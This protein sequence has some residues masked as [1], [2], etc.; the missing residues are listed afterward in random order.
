MDQFKEFAT[1]KTH[2]H[3]G[4]VF[5]RYTILNNIKYR[6]YNRSQYVK[7]GCECGAEKL[8]YYN[9]LNL[10]KSKS[11][12]CLAKEITSKISRSKLV[13]KRFGIG[14]VIKD[15]GKRTH[16]RKSIWE[17]E[18]DCGS[19][20]ESNADHL[21]SGRCKSCGCQKRGN[22]THGSI[23]GLYHNGK[24]VYVGQTIKTLK[25]RLSNHMRKNCPVSRYVKATSNRL[26]IKPLEENILIPNL[27]DLEKE[28]I[29]FYN[30][31]GVRL[32]NKYYNKH[33]LKY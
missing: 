9:S 13:G 19:I 25:A 4:K 20:Y 29:K 21:T 17:L 5:E 16:N 28:Y 1:D 32:L 7:C 6:K 15:T 12:G 31:Y 23:Y 18:C 22:Q 10:G 27:N 8:V 3:K 14:V 30:S 2:E 26:T 33:P 24:I 11:C